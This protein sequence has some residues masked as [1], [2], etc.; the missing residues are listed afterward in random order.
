MSYVTHMNE[1]CLTYEWVM[2]HIWMSHLTNI[3]TRWRRP[4]GCL[5]FVGHFPK[6]SPIISGSSAKRDLQLKVSYVFSPTCSYGPLHV[7]LI[8]FFF[9]KE[10]H[11]LPFSFPFSRSFFLAASRFRARAR[12]TRI[13]SCS[14]PLCLSCS[15]QGSEDTWDA[16]SCR[17]L[18]AKEPLI[19]GLFC[20]KWPVKR[21]HPMHPRHRVDQV[22][23]TYMY[24]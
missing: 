9:E 22:T 4:I 2:S 11:A 15:V 5:I 14:C 20:G 1:S 3:A 17:S 13:H 24:S 12:C 6:K 16:L 18:S 23:H 21:S 7:S 10:E 8:V 19:I